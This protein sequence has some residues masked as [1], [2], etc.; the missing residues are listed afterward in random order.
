MPSSSTITAFY[1]FTAN[2]RARASQVNANFSIFRG[3][4]LPVDPNTQTAVNNTY[5]LGSTE[6]RWRTGY[7]KTLDFDRSGANT[8]TVSADANTSAA[9]L[10]F[11]M[12]GVEKAR[13]NTNGLFSPLAE[14]GT[15][16]AS[17]GRLALGN[18]IGFST[19][20]LNTSSTSWAGSTITLAVTGRAVRIFTTP[21]LVGTAASQYFIASRNTTTGGNVYIT[22]YRGDTAVSSYQFPV[23]SVYQPP[24]RAFLLDWTDT[25][26]AGTHVYSLKYFADGTSCELIHNSFRMVAKEMF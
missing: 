22:L 19:I 20:S 16:S 13:I 7:F 2:S 8:I 24:V 6:Y 4:I 3:H 15:I 12:G 17:A 18:T 9:E 10:V 14:A 11:S 1:S 23:S 21:A 26:P 25:P 5:D